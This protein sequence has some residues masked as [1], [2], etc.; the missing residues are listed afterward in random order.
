MNA[1]HIALEHFV[2][3]SPAAAVALVAMAFLGR[4]VPQADAQTGTDPAGTELRRMTQ[5]M[6]DAVAPGQAEVWQRYTHERLIHVDENG[7]VRSRK[8][9]LAEITPLPPGRER[10]SP[11]GG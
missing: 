10:A 1:L 5:E 7:T 11:P 8:E 3:R 6:L 9:L 4:A 2:T